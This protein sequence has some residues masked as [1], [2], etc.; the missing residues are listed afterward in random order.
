[1][2]GADDPDTVTSGETA[3]PG[4]DV[5]TSTSGRPAEEAVQKTSEKGALRRCV[6]CVA[7]P[8]A[9]GCPG[10]QQRPGAQRC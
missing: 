2:D 6:A 9:S 1:M 4:T 7:P 3:Q 8:G 5:S 10:R